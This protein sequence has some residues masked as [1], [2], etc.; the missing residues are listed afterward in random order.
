[1][2]DEISDRIPIDGLSSL[3]C[4]LVAL[5]VPVM[6]AVYCYLARG[7]VA[8]NWVA[9]LVPIFPWLF[10]LRLAQ[11]ESQSSVYSQ[12]FNA[13]LIIVGSMSMVYVGNFH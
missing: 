9:L 10:Y 5:A 3:L 2:R 6:H 1:M 7:E 12:L 11:L 13:F 4:C 8:V